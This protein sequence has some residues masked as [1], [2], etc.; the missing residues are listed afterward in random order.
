MAREKGN[1]HREL[2]TRIFNQAWN[3]ADFSGLRELIAEDA[4]FHIRGQTFPTSAEDL[5]RI[6]IGW[7]ETFADFHF[8]IQ[9]MVVER[10]RVAVRLTLS[11]THQGPWQGIPAAGTQVS[12]TAMMFFHLADGKVVEI[13]ENYDEY[14]LRQQLQGE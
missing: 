12:V 2:V 13:W 14:G 10:D 1:Q 8:E 11:G 6:V 4:A 7:H 3:Q 9:D 5:Q